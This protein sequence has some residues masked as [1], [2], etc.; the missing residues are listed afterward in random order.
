MVEL[1]TGDG[2]V[3]GPDGRRYWGKFGAAG[4]LAVDPRERILLQHRS[5][6]SHQGG[7]WA[8]PGGA[9]D[10]GEDAQTGA[11]REARE[12]AGVPGDAIEPWFE[13]V[14]DF[15]FWS[16]TTC[17]MRVT[18]EFEPVISDPESLELRWVHLDE[19]ATYP[20]HPGFAEAWPM[21]LDR[22]RRG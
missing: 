1:R 5:P 2:W 18:L 21:L 3:E 9:R 22:I 14:V 10:A 15:G 7:T 4:L 8:L 11:L 6:H 16:Y 12:E 20:L 13:H 19:V 17:V